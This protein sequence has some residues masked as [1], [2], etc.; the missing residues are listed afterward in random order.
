MKMKIGILTYHRAHNY[1]ALLQAFGLKTYLESQ[2]HRTEIIDYWPI[3]H[4]DDYALI[5]HFK[6]RRILS[7]IKAILL[8]LI[9]YSRIVIRTKS[10]IF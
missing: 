6:S 5:P 3:Y 7:K 1:G 2:G 4:K 10:S 9:G 8:L